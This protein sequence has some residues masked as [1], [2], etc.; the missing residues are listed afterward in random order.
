MTSPSASSTASFSDFLDFDTDGEWEV[1]KAR[2]PAIHAPAEVRDIVVTTYRV[3]WL[4]ISDPENEFYA[5]NHIVS[6]VIFAESHH[7]A[8]KKYFAARLS[9]ELSET[10]KEVK[11]H[12]SSEQSNFLRVLSSLIF[13]FF[14]QGHG[15]REHYHPGVYEISLLTYSDPTDGA[16]HSR[17]YTLKEGTTIGRFIEKVIS[18]QIHLGR[19]VERVW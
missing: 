13:F 5:K 4:D 1:S 3:E 17:T 6:A 8:G 12:R 10:L 7:I 16:A 14:N 2:G 15:N 18:R 19:Q 9:M 11:D